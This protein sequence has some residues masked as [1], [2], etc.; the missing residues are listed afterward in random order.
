MFRVC[1]IHIF[2]LSYLEFMQKTLYMIW[3]WWC[4]YI[5][6]ICTIV[7]V[8]FRVW[9]EKT[10][11]YL[12]IFLLFQPSSVHI[13]YVPKTLKMKKI[14]SSEKKPS[15]AYLRP[16]LCFGP[17]QLLLSPNNDEIPFFSEKIFSL[18]MFVICNLLRPQTQSLWKNIQLHINFVSYLF[19]F[20]YF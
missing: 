12:P 10:Y 5:L 2:L 9:L 11:E 20:F 18:L 17:M 3:W 4:Q 6:S 7:R 19:S 16:F 14:S 8:A 15:S 13:W 1:T